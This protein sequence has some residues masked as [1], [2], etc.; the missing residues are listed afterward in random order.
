[1]VTVKDILAFLQSIAPD[2]MKM[3]WDNVGLLCGSESQSVEK[4]L[5]ALDPFEEVCK[6]AAAWDADLIVTHHPLIFQGL[7][8]IT[9]VTG[10]GRSIKI[11]IE[12]GICA[13]NAHTN[14]DCAPGG[15]NDALAQ[16]L[17]LAD[18]Q[19]IDPAGVTE[20]GAA[21]G[22]LRKGIVPQ[23]SLSD[24]LKQVKEALG[25]QG[26]RYASGGQPVHK[27]AVGGGS[28]GDEL[29]A[30]AAAGCDTFVTADVK[31]NQFADAAS[32]GI[33][34]IDAGHFCTE[35]PVVSVLAKQIQQKFPEIAVKTSQ[36]H[37]D[38]VN[39]Y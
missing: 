15:V 17:S 9:D 2:Y 30:V 39:F 13:V 10:I 23:Q 11:L 14:L 8:S 26:L 33:N 25:C 35:N 38:C 37:R 24:F 18:I 7:K 27:V 16:T 22:L 28:C 12:N 19:I 21:W 29:A 3:E 4:V 5:V 36:V 20:T 1:M 32:M 34:L 6:E 31:Y